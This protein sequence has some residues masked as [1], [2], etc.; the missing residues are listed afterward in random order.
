MATT[1]N[2]TKSIAKLKKRSAKIDK[3]LKQAIQPLN[4]RLKSMGMLVWWDGKEYR[5][6]PEASN[7]SN[8]NLFRL[9]DHGLAELMAMTDSKLE[10]F[11]KGF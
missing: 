8:G 10:S 7:S 2:E 3:Q 1:T 11:L 5:F 6:N 9:G 4:D